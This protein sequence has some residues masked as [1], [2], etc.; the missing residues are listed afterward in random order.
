MMDPASSVDGPVLTERRGRVLVITLNRPHALNA[1]DSAVSLGVARALERLDGDPDL[2]A[3]VLTGAGR[4]FCAGADLKALAAGVS[5]DSPEH[6]HLG[7]GGLVRREG[8]KP[9]VAAVN[10]A[11]MGGGVEL[12]LACDLVVAAESAV[13]AL[14]EVRR[15]LFAAAGALLR[16]PGRVPLNAALEMVLT[17]AAVPADRAREWGLVN[18][19]VPAG[20]VL[21]EAVALADIVAA[22]APLALEVSRRL[23]LRSAE[24]TD[25]RAAWAEND[26]EFARL[27]ASEDGREGPRAFAER[28]APQWVGR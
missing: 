24:Q 26:E 13:L 17:G 7:F 18:R 28:R 27:L 19:V 11:A 14:P 23:L 22:N 9:L 3:G 4:A 25:S 12:L 1:V 5:V 10:G 2:G 15:G 21:D 6:P 20:S 8:G 16:L